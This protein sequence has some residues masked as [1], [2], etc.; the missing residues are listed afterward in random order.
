MSD[1]ENSEFEKNKTTS[2]H[3]LES[4]LASA[5]RDENYGKNI[6]KII[7]NPD[8]TNLYSNE[9]GD[10]F[11]NIVSTKNII[12]L[13]VSLL[14]ISSIVFIVYILNKANNTTPTE[15]SVEPIST[16]TVTSTSTDSPII[17]GAN[18]LNPEIIQ[19]S[20]FSKMNRVEIVN[21]LNNIK[22][23]LITK[24]VEPNNNIAINTNLNIIQFFEKMRYSGNE[25]FLRSLNNTYTFGMYSVKDSKFE[26]YLLVSV[27][28][29]DLAFKSI[30]DWERF[31]PVDLKDIFVGNNEIKQSRSNSTSSTSTDII[32]YSKKN[33]NG[34]VDKILKNYDIREYVNNESNLNIVYGFINNKYLLITSGESSFIDIKDRL[35]KENISR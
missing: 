5:V 28:D 31:M 33:T 3:T 18:I 29:F 2:I 35:L 6:I 16:S 26:T 19:Y 15:D 17:L 10:M 24:K 27:S 9:R 32:F 34:F 20:N 23:L 30:L 4:D 12:I 21:E 14:V 1:N 7:T 11:K 25:S 8:K 22:N 13:T